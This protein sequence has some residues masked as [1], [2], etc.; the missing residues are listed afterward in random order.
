MDYIL[1][2]DKKFVDKVLAMTSYMVDR[3]DIKFIPVNTERVGVLVA[4]D[5]Y[6]HPK[7]ED[8][9]QPQFADEKKPRKQQ[10]KSQ[11]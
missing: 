10:P 4:D 8:V 5:K 1:T 9:K 6:V 7:P 2:G 3:G 11:E